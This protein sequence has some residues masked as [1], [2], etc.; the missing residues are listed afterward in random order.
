MV[1]SFDDKA[2]TWDENPRRIKLVENIWKE[3]ER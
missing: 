3:L 1:N 2:A